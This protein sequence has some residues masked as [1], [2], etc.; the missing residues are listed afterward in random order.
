MAMTKMARP[1]FGGALRSTCVCGAKIHRRRVTD[2][3]VHI[4]TEKRECPE[5]S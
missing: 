5:K 2:R 4:G 1:A 3:W